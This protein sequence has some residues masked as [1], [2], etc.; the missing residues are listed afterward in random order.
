MVKAA[1]HTGTYQV[2]RNKVVALANAN[3]LTLCWSC[4]R[5]LNLHPPH[6]NGKPVAW[7]GGHTVRGSTT[8]QPWLRPMVSPTDCA[9]AAAGDWIAPEVSSCNY[10]DRDNNPEQI[11]TTRRW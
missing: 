2:S 5:P 11:T 8:A 7:T 10:A 6:A 1:H 9:T 4:Q 3:P